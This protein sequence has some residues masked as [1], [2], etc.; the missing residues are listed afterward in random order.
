M[1]FNHESHNV[2]P[3]LLMTSQDT[4]YML[5]QGERSLLVGQ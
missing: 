5:G 2:N 1:L 3:I 4:I